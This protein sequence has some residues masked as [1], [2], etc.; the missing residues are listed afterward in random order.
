M[1][2]PAVTNVFVANTS[3][4]AGQVN[5]NFSDLVL[6]ISNRNDGSA[7]WDRVLVTSS[8][9][10]PLVINNSTGTTNIANFQDNG[11]TVFQI[12]D[13]GD[14]YMNT[15]KK[16]YL[17]GGTNTYVVGATTTLD[18][19]VAGTVY[20]RVN[21]ASTLTQIISADFAIPSTKKIFLDAGGDTYILE[22]SANRIQ[23][24]TGGT[25]LLDLNGG[26]SVINILAA[27]LTIPATKLLYLDGGGDT[28]IS[29][30]S[31]NTMDFATAGTAAL[32]ITSAQIIDFRNAVIAL[33]GGSAPTFGTIGATGPATAGQNSWL[34]IKIAGTDS[35]IPIWR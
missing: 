17:D 1:T 30:S 8:S 35:Y 10:V 12:V 34:K 14:V 6:Y 3:A 20:F 29:E 4:Q 15:G 27:D 7:T 13:G 11:T 21:S 28:T 22:N 25:T 9:S 32:R 16:L 33:G 19:A 26:G 23:F 18:L 31:A 24:V 2:A 5:T